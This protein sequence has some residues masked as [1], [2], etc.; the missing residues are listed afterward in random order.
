MRH[1]SFYALALSVFLSPLLLGTVHMW[2]S[3]LCGALLSV[4]VLCEWW[5]RR[6]GDEPVRISGWSLVM[7]G[8]GLWSLIQCIPLPPALLSALAPE[9][10]RLHLEAL[11]V[12]PGSAPVAR[13]VSLDVPESVARG[14]R[15]LCLAQ[16][17]FLCVNVLQ[18]RKGIKAEVVLRNVVLISG[19]AALGVGLVHRLIG[20]EDFLG[21]VATSVPVRG[22]SPFVNLN[23]AASFYGMCALLCV[24]QL[25]FAL[26]RSTPS[27]VKIGLYSAGTLVFMLSSF[28]HESRSVTVFLVIALSG[29]CVGFVERAYWGRRFLNRINH[30]P[31][32]VWLG[33]TLFVFLG[34]LFVFYG[35]DA[36]QTFWGWADV[37]GLSRWLV[38]KGALHRSVD[39][40]A[41][42]SGAGTVDHVIYAAVDFSQIPT[43][44]IAVA[45]NEAF[46]WLLTLGW[47]VA[48]VALV[49]MGASI[50]MCFPWLRKRD[51]SIYLSRLVLLMFFVYALVIFSFHF[52]FVTLG[53][54]LPLVVVM[55]SFFASVRAKLRRQERKRGRE[56]SSRVGAGW[57][58][59]LVGA[60]VGCVAVH[61]ATTPRVETVAQLEATQRSDYIQHLHAHPADGRMFEWMARRALGEGD[62]ALAERAAR[63][64]FALQPVAPNAVLWAQ[65][66][67]RAG[68]PEA[69]IAQ[70]ERV[71]D[72]SFKSFESTWLLWMLEDVRDEAD[73][74][75]VLAR[76]DDALWAR[77][78]A[79]ILKVQGPRV[80][81]DLLLELVAL[82]PKQPMAYRLLIEQYLGEGLHELAM[83]WAQLM[84]SRFTGPQSAYAHMLLHRALMGQQRPQD[85]QRVLEQGLT[86]HP[87]SDALWGVVLDQRPSSEL[88]RQQLRAA[89]DRLCT[90]AKTKD[91]ARVCAQAF[92]RMVEESEPRKAQKALE[93]LAFQYEDIKPLIEF[94]IRRG[95]CLRLRR[96]AS[97]W[98][99]TR[100]KESKSR[101]TDRALDAGVKRC[102]KR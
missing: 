8:L 46:E 91:R 90:A 51:A 4:G 61:A 96:F 37:D 49:G 6:S 58:A 36:A 2:T 3:T 34:A 99:S 52:P 74:A 63:R 18:R 1:G 50:R 66:Q 19:V 14:L 26:R 85:A 86:A 62:D 12:L 100:S 83:V 89:Y 79:A 82:R 57:A 72:G 92:V 102:T 73:R 5:A 101:H 88:Q 47:P 71:F 42:G 76:A 64:A 87:D 9:V 38:A 39:F 21:L 80:A 68:R 22:F 30:L 67:H 81:Q 95:E 41:L 60:C 77:A 25:L 98:Q 84:R 31:R 17:S 75:R 69:A 43:A 97:M 15:W 78:H 56:V 32:S 44:R 20:S 24:A 94:H 23:H 33:V 27:P 53:L 48:A 16:A 40:W 7:G 35:L 10:H 28:A 11:G 13:P 93:Q 54:G 70:W 55:E 45:E 59:L 29:L 65:A